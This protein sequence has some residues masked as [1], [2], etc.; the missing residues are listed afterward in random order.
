[1]TSQKPDNKKIVKMYEKMFLIR[2]CEERIYYL[3]LE[4]ILSGTVHQSQGQEASAVGMLFDLEKGDY[5]TSTHR[6]TG[7]ALAKG[8]SL[9]SVM[10]EIFAKSTGCCKAKGGS[11]HLGDMK[12]GAVPSIAIVGG[13]MPVA[14]GIGL[15]CK[16]RKTKNVVVCFFGDGASNEGAFHEAL[17]GAA[18]WNLPVIFACENNLYGASTRINKVMK[19]KN[20]ADRASAYGIQGEVVDGNNVLEVN[21]TA[22]KAIKRAREGKGPALIEIKTY[23][24]VGHSRRDANKYR[25]KKEEKEWFAK[26]PVKKLREYILENKVMDDKKLLEQIEKD[27]L[28]EIEQAVEY[29]KK[30]P[31]PKPEDALEDVYFEMRV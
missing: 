29:A 12:V 10:A 13:G 18:I 9:N 30:S 15:S 26:D 3:F 27:I 20:I 22:L 19:P 7:H 11:M 8:V 25:D 21:R 17:N 28:N 24:I 2:K 5:M 23:R 1:M 16:M 14:V 4:G 6:A 31:E